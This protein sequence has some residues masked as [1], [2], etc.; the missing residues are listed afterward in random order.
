MPF[1]V[2][3]DAVGALAPAG[4]ESCV[5]GNAFTRG[6]CGGVLITSMPA[7]LN[8]ASKAA[9]IIASRSAAGTA[10]PELDVC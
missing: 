1:V 2:D 9:V 10:N 4:A 3:Q 5:F 8:T 7:A 6:A